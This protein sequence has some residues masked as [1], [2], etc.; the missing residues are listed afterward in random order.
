MK[1]LLSDE[2]L[3]RQL[4]MGDEAAYRIVYNRYWH[5]IYQV[6]LMYLKLPEQAEDVVQNIFLKLWAK[7]AQLPAI[8]KIEGYL[9]MMARNEVISGMRKKK[10]DISRYELPTDLV[11]EDFLLPQ[12]LLVFRESSALIYKAI[13]L[14][15]PQQQHIFKMSREQGLSHDEIAREMGISKEAVKKHITRALSA[16]R[17]FLQEHQGDELLLCWILSGSSLLLA[18]SDF[19]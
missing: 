19:F 12:Q 11:E 9:F 2:E 8:E 4:A 13:S 15:P 3:S 7:R 5:K 16:L 10:L 17:K 14:L 18:G 6:A 1:S